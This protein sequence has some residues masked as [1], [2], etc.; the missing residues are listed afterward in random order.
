MVTHHLGA[1]RLVADE[2][3]FLKNGMVH[4]SGSVEGLDQS[5][6]ASVREFLH[7]DGMGRE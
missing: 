7:A 5:D 2:V 6:D 4:Y 3:V 1:M